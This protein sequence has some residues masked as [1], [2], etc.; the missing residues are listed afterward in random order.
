MFRN[1]VQGVRA[2]SR[3]ESTEREMDEELRGFLEASAAEKVRRGMPEAEAVRAARIEMGSTNVVKHRIRSA[4]WE[5]S[6]EIFLQDLRYGFRTLLRSPGF[7]IVAV[8]SLALG[9][10]ANTAIF[11]LIHQVLLTDLPVRDP[12]QLVTFDRAESGGVMGGVDLGFVGMF[13]WSFTRQVEANHGPFAGIASYCSFT[14]MVSVRLPAASGSGPAVI[15]PAHLV[16]GN[17][18]NVLGASPMLGRVISPADD[19]APGSGAVVVLSHRFWQQQLSADQGVLGRTIN[20]NG[21]PFA[22]I[23]VM[24]EGFYGVHNDLQPPDLWTPIS[25][26][27]AVLQQPSFLTPNGYYFLH[28]FGR[29][30]PALGKAAWGQSQ[31]W[32]NQQVQTWMMDHEGAK[33]TAERRREI[34]RITVPLIS[35]SRGVSLVRSQFG[36]SLQVLM[37]VVGLVLLIACANLA[38]FLL[39]RA[40]ARQRE[41]AT[42]LALGSSRTRIMQQGLAETLLLSLAGGALGLGVAFAATRA[43]IAFVTRGATSVTLQAAPDGTVLLFTLGVSLATA[44]L[45][46]LA[47]AIAAARTGAGASLHSGARTAESSG[48]RGSRFWPRVLITAQVMLSVLLLVGA[49]LYLRTLRNLQNQDYGFERTHL[50]LADIDERL[51]GYHTTQVGALH[52][53]LLERLAAIPG[54]R[55]AAL[56]LTPPIS[57]GAWS[58]SISLSGYTPAPKENMSSVLN[59]VSGHYFETAGIGLVAGRYINDSDTASSM[60]VAVINETVAKKYYPKGDAV[61]HSMK[62]DFDDGTR[63]FQIVGVVRDTHVNNPRN[64]DPV[65]MSYVALA[66]ME[67]LTV[68]DANAPKNPDGSSPA[69]QESQDVFAGTVLLRT[70][71]DPA[72]AV[73]ALRAAVASVDPGLPLLQVQTITEQVS[74]MMSRDELISTLTGL[75][76]ALALLLAAIGLYGVMSYSVVRRTSEIGIRIALGA[77]TSTVQW[78]VLRESLAVF[79][80]GIALGV[81]A[82]LLLVRLVRAQLFGVSPFDPGVF[83]SSVVVIG[84]VSVLSAWLPA[85][86]AAGVDPMT[87]L[88]CE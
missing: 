55:S 39:A 64:T 3:R 23:G 81:P 68:V 29:L 72:Q 82:A 32:L 34:S 35:A 79:A 54:V 14:N 63:P 30:N 24:P 16:S 48:G 47:P 60:K 49:G 38:N 44:L 76:S 88:R 67:P 11:T 13:P 53:E 8:V 33:L 70:T 69:P 59:R 51:A 71:G 28:L 46:G 40:T 37:V 45:F 18:F 43:L 10:G 77:S 6:M 75:F 21:T 74:G 2:L 41:I 17:Y 58:S 73:S 78:M 5:V 57:Y 52:Q 15:V 86:R 19:A 1:L 65:R 26:Q 36:D 50:L 62:I 9:I 84:A 61:G 27:V 4:T 83:V 56:S 31:A 7:A 85:R 80:V 66:Q 20:I 22:V 25:M 87:A 12:E 42:R